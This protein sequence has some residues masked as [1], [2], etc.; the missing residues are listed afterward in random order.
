MSK[1]DDLENEI[2]GLFNSSIETVEVRDEVVHASHIANR[3]RGLLDAAAMISVG[4]L[5][6]VTALFAPGAKIESV[7]HPQIIKGDS[8][9]E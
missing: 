1:S 7:K 3:H 2:R 5:A 4:A 8:A 6:V 9:N